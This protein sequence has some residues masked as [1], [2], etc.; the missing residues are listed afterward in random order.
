MKKSVILAL[1]FATSSAIN[2]EEAAAPIAP[3]VNT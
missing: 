3:V 2:L 1:L